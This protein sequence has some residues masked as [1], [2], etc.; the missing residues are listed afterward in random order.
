MTIIAGIRHPTGV[1]MA[2]DSAAAVGWTMVVRD[3]V[4]LR[5]NGHYLIGFTSSWRMGQLLHYALKPP[6]PPDDVRQ[7]HEFMCTTWVDAVRD[8][9]KAGG[10]AKVENNQEQGGAFLVGVRGRLFIV[11]ADYQVGEPADEFAAVGCGDDA[12]HGAM[13]ATRGRP[14]RRRLMAAMA[15]AERFSNGV[16]GPFTYLSIRAGQ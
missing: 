13:H 5:R 4:K 7:L 9:L 15:A 16:R 1:Y 3:D 12:A 8:C 6:E 2:A 10:W 14:P 11:H